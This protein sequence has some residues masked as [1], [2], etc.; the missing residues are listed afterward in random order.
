MPIIIYATL[1]LE[2]NPIILQNNKINYYLPGIKH[3][4]FNKIV[5]WKW[6]FLGFLEAAL[7]LLNSVYTISDNFVNDDGHNMNFWGLGFMV[8]GLVVVLVNFKV[9]IISFD[10]TFLSMFF[11][12]G[13]ILLYIVFFLMLSGIE[14]SEAFNVFN[15]LFK[16]F[17]FHVGNFLTIFM[18]SFMI[19]YAIERY[20][21]C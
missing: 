6:F 17:A 21:R 20:D 11:N 15:V 18:V 4:L 8:Y 10:H 19:D 1:D 5:F 14:S 13:S 16:S 2:F 12:I 7:L 9:L 3:Q